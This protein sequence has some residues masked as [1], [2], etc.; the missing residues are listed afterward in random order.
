M[1]GLQKSWGARFAVLPPCLDLIVVPIPASLFQPIIWLLA[2]LLAGPFD[3]WPDD[4]DVSQPEP[5]LS[6]TT[7]APTRSSPRLRSIKH[8][9]ARRLSAASQHPDQNDPQ[10]GDNEFR[11]IRS[12]VQ[13]SNPPFRP[14]SA[15][16]RSRLAP[17]V[18]SPMLDGTGPCRLRC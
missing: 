7:L 2:L 18:S 8:I 13:P 14:L 10:D 15:G 12:S 3:D 5:G 16:S 11:P 17:L 1:H 6:I 4:S 9:P